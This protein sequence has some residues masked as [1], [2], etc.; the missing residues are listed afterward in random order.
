MKKLIL[1]LA[2]LAVI[3]AAFSFQGCKKEEVV[4]NK[5]LLQGFKWKRT[6][7]TTNGQDSFG[8]YLACEKDDTDTFKADGNLVTD[9]GATK[10]AASDPQTTTLSYTLSA[11]EKTIVIKD[12]GFSIDHKILEISKTNL[13]LEY[14]FLGFTVVETYTRQ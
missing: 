5:S 14:M 8:D 11:D 13:K 10:C 1:N 9:E 4:T 3:V 2:L 12:S 7:E 6:A